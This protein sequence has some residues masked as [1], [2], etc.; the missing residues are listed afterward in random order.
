MNGNV[1][2]F[3]DRYREDAALRERVAAAEAAYPGSLEIREAVVENVL[4]PIAEELGLPFTV[5]D[6]RA[7]E[8]RLKMKNIQPDVPIPEGEPVDDDPVSY[9][10][11][12]RGWENDPDIFRK[13]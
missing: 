11:L 4:L 1:G 12:D 2:L 10:L 9:W 3:F 8:T 6:L 13:K 7:Y 5:K